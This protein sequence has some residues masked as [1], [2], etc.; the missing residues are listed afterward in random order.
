M[1]ASGDRAKAQDW[2]RGAVLYQIYPLSFM[3]GDGDG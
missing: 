1:G 3:E 2:W